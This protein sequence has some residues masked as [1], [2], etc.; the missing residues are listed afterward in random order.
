MKQL[1]SLQNGAP[2]EKIDKRFSFYNAISC[3]THNYSSMSS[4]I[5]IRDNY[6]GLILYTPQPSAEKYGQNQMLNRMWSIRRVIVSKNS[7]HLKQ[8][9]LLSLHRTNLS[10]PHESWNASVMTTK[11]Y[12]Y[13]I[14]MMH[15][16]WTRLTRYQHSFL[17]LQRNQYK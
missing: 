2:R 16:K 5:S 1:E 8:Q 14:T 12:G 6:Y 3:I 17:K 9:V 7:I 4:D 13:I 15:S 10:N 11:L